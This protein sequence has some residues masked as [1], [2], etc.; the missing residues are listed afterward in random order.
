MARSVCEIQREAESLAF[1]STLS[2]ERKREERERI[3]R[4][5]G[6]GLLGGRPLTDREIRE[7]YVLIQAMVDCGELRRGCAVVHDGEGKCRIVET[8]RT[9]RLGRYRPSTVG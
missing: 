9:I 6:K 3:L 2:A 1:L 7:R 5:F 8:F 4:A